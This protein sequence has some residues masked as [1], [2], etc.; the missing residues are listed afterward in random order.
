MTLDKPI[1]T[2]DQQL[3][4][5]STE[6]MEVYRCPDSEAESNRDGLWA[7]VLS[8]FSHDTTLKRCGIRMKK[9]VWD[10]DARLSVRYIAS[11]KRGWL[12]IFG[13]TE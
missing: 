5:N 6:V 4:P 13:G 11:N 8:R 9:S 3:T 7:F 10:T 12:Y 2:E 1:E